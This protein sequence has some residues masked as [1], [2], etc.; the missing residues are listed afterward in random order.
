MTTILQSLS[1][2]EQLNFLLTNRIPRRA[3]TQF[4][5]WYSRIENRSL[6]RASLR[7][8]RTFAADLD[9]EEAEQREFASLHDCFTRRL[10]P[11]ARTI[12]ARADIVVSPCDAI[13]G[14]CGSIDGTRVFQAK[15]FPYELGELMPDT[16]LQE[17]YRNGRYVT[18]RLKSSMY[19]RFHAPVAC[20][21]DDIT[22]ISGDT[23]N[24]NPVAL[25]RIEKLYCRNERAVVPLSQLATAGSVCLVPVAAILVASMKFH[26]LPDDLDLHYQGPNRI[27]CSARYKKGEEMG[28]F[29]HGSTIIVFAT[30]NYLLSAGVCQGQTIRMGQALL[31]DTAAAAQQRASNHS[32]E[33]PSRET[34][35]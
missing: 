27:R 34:L 4:M 16:G 10:K 28:Y 19:H 14:E 2:H 22:Y 24:V 13:V 5:G 1:Q 15:G 17:R 25:R 23:W 20:T 11:G 9:L 26:C 12:D 6:T 8:W 31:T 29:Q 18:L 3:L 30:S 21:V 7:L 35:D 33:S 32:E